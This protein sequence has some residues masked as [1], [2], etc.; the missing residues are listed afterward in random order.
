MSYEYRQRLR[1]REAAKLETAVEVAVQT[2]F[3]PESGDSAVNEIS[4]DVAGEVPT[5]NIQLNGEE[6]NT[7][8]VTD[9][10]PSA[11]AVTDARVAEIVAEIHALPDDAAYGVYMT[12][13]SQK[14]PELFDAVNGYLH[15][16]AGTMPLTTESP[17]NGE[18]NVPPVVSTPNTPPVKKKK[19]KVANVANP[20][21][22][23]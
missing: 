3:V 23:N 20:E 14:D 9:N 8:V 5:Q 22:N 13:L 19:G 18:E 4:G 16:A 21:S 17:L 10:T 11:V 15:E 7:P 12:E 1:E 6:S 2:Q